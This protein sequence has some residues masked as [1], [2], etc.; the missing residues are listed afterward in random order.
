MATKMGKTAE[1]RLEEHHRKMRNI[2]SDGLSAYKNRNRM[3]Q[4]DMGGVLGV[5]RETVGALLRGENV[6]ISYDALLRVFDVAGIELTER[7]SGK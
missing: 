1:Q 5:G 4:E 6:K 3:S 2:V 7:R